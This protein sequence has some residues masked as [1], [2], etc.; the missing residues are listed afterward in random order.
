MIMLLRYR[1]HLH[2]RLLHSLQL[3]IL[4]RRLLGVRLQHRYQGFQRAIFY[5]LLNQYY[6]HLLP[7]HL[8]RN[9]RQSYHHRLGL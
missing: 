5:R 7:I 4:H 6:R 8:D 9:H 1:S 2:R 3:R